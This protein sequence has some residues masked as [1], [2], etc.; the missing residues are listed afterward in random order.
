VLLF[1]RQTLSD[2]Q[3]IAFSRRLGELDLAPL[4]PG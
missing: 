2:D 4:R 1:R 3:L